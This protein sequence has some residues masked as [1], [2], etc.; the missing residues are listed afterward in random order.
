MPGIDD[1]LMSLAP[2]SLEG[3]AANTGFIM[4]RCPFHGGGMEKTPSCSLSR[5]KPVFFCHACN[6]GG[7]IRKFLQAVG[8]SD[9]ASKSII[10][11]VSYDYSE[12]G[13]EQNRHSI[14]SGDNP[15]KGKFILDDEILDGWRLR[16]RTLIDAG[17]REATLRHFEVGVDNTERRITFPIRNLY[18]DLIGVSGR[19][20][21]DGDERPRYKIYSTKELARFDVQKEYTTREIKGATLW[22]A[23]MVYPLAFQTSGDIIITEGFKAAMW[24]WQQGYHNVVALIGAHL[25][26]LQAELLARTG[27]RIILFLDNND[28]G[29]KGTHAA[30]KLLLSTNI[31]YVAKYPDK[32]QQPDNLQEL[33]LASAINNAVHI[34]PW[35]IEQE[36]KTV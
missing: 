31:L 21:Q 9:G 19:T 11:T 32:R 35:T 2:Q 4:V 23:H 25:T 14:L 24:V 5:S 8:V 10:E 34:V 7:H 36:M 1:V 26:K 17:F 16:S 29:V 13:G 30:G 3:S 6:T 33:E 15:Y 28:A 22:H 27:S 20:Y 18:G 12:Y